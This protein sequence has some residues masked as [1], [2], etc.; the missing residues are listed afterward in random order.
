MSNEPQVWLGCLACYNAGSLIGTWMGVKE[1]LDTDS[2]TLHKKMIP[3]WKLGNSHEELWVFDHENT[4]LKGEFGLNKIKSIAKTYEE[5]GDAAWPT[6][7]AW[8]DHTGNDYLDVSTFED[9]YI[10]EWSSF[11]DYA[12]QQ[13]EDLLAC[14]EGGNGILANYFDYDQW[15]RDLSMDYN[16][17]DVDDGVAIFFP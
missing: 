11:S 4:G 16:V 1:A 5:V 10:G 6:Y 3:T 15:E 17:V 8:L 12:Y 2:E 14:T 7:I 9:N 13:A